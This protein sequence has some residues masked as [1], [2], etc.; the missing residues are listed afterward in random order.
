MCL[1]EDGED[2]LEEWLEQN[3]NAICAWMDNTTSP[4][5]NSTK[6]VFP[7]LGEEEDDDEG[8]YLGLV[9][10]V[11]DV[12]IMCISSLLRTQADESNSS[13][14]LWICTPKNLA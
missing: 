9:D 12:Q 11:D 6:N 4:C 14:W 1:Q 8:Q 7:H 10:L 13:R 5:C 2:V 3:G